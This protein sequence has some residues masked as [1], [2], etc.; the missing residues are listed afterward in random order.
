MSQLEAALAKER[1]AHEAEVSRVR[2]ELSR[3]LRE[4]QAADAKCRDSVARAEAAER[5]RDD[6]EKRAAGAERR[7]EAALSEARRLGPHAQPPAPGP[8]SAWDPRVA[9]SFV[10]S[11]ANAAAAAGAPLL[12]GLGTAGAG[13]GV[14]PASALA[15]GTQ[16][17]AYADGAPASN[18]ALAAGLAFPS[19]P[20]RG[21]SA[22]D[23]AAS[24]T[25]FLTNGPPRVSRRGALRCHGSCVCLARGFLADAN[26]LVP[27]RSALSGRMGSLL[28]SAAPSPFAAP[29]TPT[30]PP[31]P[32]F[33]FPNGQG[34]QAAVLAS[35]DADGVGMASFGSLWSQ[36]FGSDLG[37]ALPNMD[38]GAGQDSKAEPTE[39]DMSHIHHDG[40]NML[41]LSLL[42]ADTGI[43][44]GG[45]GAGQAGRGV[46]GGH[47]SGWFGT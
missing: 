40:F 16:R 44:D 45:S 7:A 42:G 9:P 47:L 19:S 5:S 14:G 41:P 25:E 6:A 31:P 33:P 13:A 17:R 20:A 24:E 22:T 34:A 32:S 11:K 29:S 8:V 10:P 1:A 23:R 36:G 37:L 27:A 2:D 3:A 21:P 39:L 12:A 15:S 38:T 46:A 4:R 28:S 43:A 18:F 26:R 30:K 35:V